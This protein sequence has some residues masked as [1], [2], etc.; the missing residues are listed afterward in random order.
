MKSKRI[1]ITMGDPA[2]IGPEIIVSF[3]ST[4]AAAADCQCVV[5]G[6]PSFLR[7]AIESMA[8]NLEV[9]E[10]D[11]VADIP[12]S[13]NEIGCIR[14]TSISF[15]DVSI[16]SIDANAGQAAVD[17]LDAAIELALDHSVNAI[18]TAPLNKKAISLAGVPFP[19]H[20]E[21]LADRCNAPDVAMMLYLD[22]NERVAGQLGLGVVHAT[23]H[24]SV[25]TAVANL[26][27]QRIVSTALL[28]G[29][30]VHNLAL[31]RKID[32]KANVG[33]AALNPHGGEQGLFG[34]EELTIIEPAVQK[35]RAM[36]DQWNCVGPL[37]CDSLMVR[38]A[39]GEFDAVVAMYHDQGHIALKLLGMKH[40]VNV[41]LGL[42]IIRTSVAHGTAFDIAWQGK[43]DPTSLSHAIKVAMELSDAKK[44]YKTTSQ[45]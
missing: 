17:A 15:D 14:C 10:I 23:L 43:A 5:L 44:K 21:L 18:V 22:H 3:W 35:V 25:K 9:V 41:T 42:P 39:A 26:S 11:S 8:L 2:G 1:A 12:S 6:H 32:R 38:A 4:I 20:T 13:P 27:E 31:A 37:P 19:G 40:A 29:E 36:V 7:K 30:F 16:A 34:D 24:E 45:T 33:V 28:A